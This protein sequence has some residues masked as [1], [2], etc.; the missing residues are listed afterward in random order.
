MR[1]IASIALAS[2]LLLPAPALACGGFFC[3]SVNLTPVQQNAERILFEIHPEGTITATVEIRYQGSPSDFSWVV[4][5]PTA[6]ADGDLELAAPTDAL[7]LLDDAT[8]PSL[9]PPPTECNE[10][11]GILSPRS[12]D[13][14]ASFSGGDDDDEGVEVI[15]LPNVGPFEVQVLSATDADALVD[16][17]NDNDYLITPEM[18]PLVGEY[19]SGGMWFLALKLEPG[20]GVA[21]IAPISMTYEGD[22][23]MV[24]IQLTGVAAEPEMGILTFIAADTR[25]EA[26][27]FTNLEISI[28]D[29]M[30]HPTTGRQNYYP[31]LSWRMDEAGGKAAVTQ[32][33][34]DFGGAATTASDRW[35]W[36]EEYTEDLAWLTELG[37]EY[38]QITRLY[39]RMSA[40]EMDEDPVFTESS[41]GNIGNVLDLSDRDP[42]DICADDANDPMPCGDMYCGVGSSCGA[43][44]EGDGCLCATG[45]VARQITAP[46]LG[47]SGV[48]TTIVCDQLDSEMLGS[49][50][51]LG[52]DA[53]DPCDTLTCGS[54]GQ[55]RALNGFPTCEC[56]E[57]YAAVA[58]GGFMTCES[59]TSTYTPEALLWTPLACGGDCNAGGEGASGLLAL[60]ALLGLVRRRK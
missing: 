29:V 11:G 48:T 1:T 3:S 21:D 16:W 15:D 26:N 18:E 59:P 9:I 53:G 10:T 47:G 31:L 6:L 35:S 39:S 14:A 5:V 24:P 44:A 37:Q 57:G 32:F 23:P 28:D 12:A 51:E 7:A 49:M 50:E 56:N 54:N 52:L 36:N 30:V 22:L 17:L 25:Y 19:V 42:V 13:Q 45:S 27:N 33:A 41:G 60:F 43:T 38:S 34:G 4:P 55:C 40:W 8:A 20:A 2:A 58:N 46:L